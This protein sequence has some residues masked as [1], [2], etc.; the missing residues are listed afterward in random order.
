MND[1]YVCT[2]SFESAGLTWYCGEVWLY[3]LL[4]HVTDPCETPRQAM[5]AAAD[6]AVN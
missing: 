3:G 6:F 4:C 2:N 1:L 5:E